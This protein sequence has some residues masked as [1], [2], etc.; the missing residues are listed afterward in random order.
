[1]SEQ[2]LDELVAALARARPVLD[3]VARARVAAVVQATCRADDAAPPRSARR[4][5]AIAA[6]S[7][8]AA[9]LVLAFALH[10]S[11]R[12][13]LISPAPP[14]S[15]QAQA[16]GELPDGA[17]LSAPRGGTVHG[18]IRGAAL[19]LYGPGWAA[20]RAGKIVVEA[21]AFVI[22][23]SAA[24]PSG[25]GAAQAAR[26]AGDPLAS[27]APAA[28]ADRIATG[29]AATGDAAPRGDA[30]ARHTADRAA[31]PVEIQLRTASI[32]VEFATFSVYESHGLQ[33]TVLRGEIVLSCRGARD[34]TI[35]AGRT[36]SCGTVRTAAI[37]GSDVSPGT[38]G[39]DVPPPGDSP[40][41][42]PLVVDPP[43]DALTANARPT[44]SDRIAATA[45]SAG[46][47]ASPAGVAADRAAA[48]APRNGVG[49][50]GPSS[51]RIAAAAPRNGVSPA[52]AASGRIASTPPASG[53]GAGR[54]TG[55]TASNGGTRA[56]AATPA[57]GG[58]HAA[59][60]GRASSAARGSDRAA[61]DRGVTVDSVSQFPFAA[62]E[63]AR[64]RGPAA[65]PPA[66]SRIAVD[67]PRFDAAAATP[68]TPATPA[69]RY[70]TAERLIGREPAAARVA[71]RAIVDEM[72]EAP[73]AAPALLDLARLA[74][75][76]GDEVAA[77][78]A[79]TQLSAHP[80][81]AALAMPAAY[82]RCT[83][84][85]TRDEYRSCLAAFRVAFPD[86]PR[87][88]E[89][90]AALA[91]ATARAGDCASARPLFE[92]SMRRYPDGPR[93]GDVR[94]WRAHCEARK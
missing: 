38:T 86:S 82:L 13:S 48:A 40:A 49:P 2:Q 15:A 37:P 70:A 74:A 88:A 16:P 87:D 32:H 47:A 64:A 51:D 28:P 5:W 46:I 55:P 62:G 34:R 21:D 52:G 3:D 79:L 36:A 61:A 91:I 90:L 14:A 18:R 66:D 31:A 65:P 1:M 39:S 8:A 50:T 69:E 35:T 54:I 58:S 81:A 76:A 17:L 63:P 30:I 68:P 89:V 7:V 72:P 60:A 43:P 84:E 6:A 67:L 27:T 93:A 23:R 29:G 11:A 94:A 42:A 71:L 44:P 20:R 85:H 4:R 33:V 56:G 73:E 19:T 53:G 41:R 25:A 83:L 24:E 22:D 9:A 80:A 78:A 57:T 77:K 75:A 26:S 92:E 45:P 12:H 10:D 59:P